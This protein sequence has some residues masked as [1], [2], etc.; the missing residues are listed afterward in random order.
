MIAVA[1][2]RY[3]SL[4]FALV[5]VYGGHAEEVVVVVVVVDDDDDD[6]MQD[7]DSVRIELFSQRMR[8]PGAFYVTLPPSVAY[9]D[10]CCCS[11]CCRCLQSAPANA[12]HTRT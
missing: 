2:C 12:E 7:K 10:C 3:H 4:V 5:H 8:G 11:C 1:C 9:N 6:D